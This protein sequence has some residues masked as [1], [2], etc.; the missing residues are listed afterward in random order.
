MT[1]VQTCALPIYHTK[2]GIS[3]DG[4]ASSVEAQS[5]ETF[6]TFD[7]AL[8]P[9]GMYPQRDPA[10]MCESLI[11]YVVVGYD[12]NQKVP[13]VYVISLDIDWNK[14][15]HE[16]PR[17]VLIYPPNGKVDLGAYF[18]LGEN[19]GIS[20]I[21]D[22]N[23]YAYKY[24]VARIPIETNKFNARQNL[25]LDE[26]TKLARVLID[27]EKQIDP[28]LVGGNTTVIAIPITGVATSTTYPEEIEI[29]KKN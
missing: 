18:V 27:V 17:K 15:I 7:D 23:S 14:K 20:S 22:P 10:T 12:D 4:L 29:A 9:E 2:P 13:K 21:R 28:N 16:G 24:A 11:R 19:A 6:S 8:G 25:T 1:G 3:I 5:R 26:A